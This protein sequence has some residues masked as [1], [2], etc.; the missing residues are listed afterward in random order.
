MGHAVGLDAAL[1][2]D[3]SGMSIV[4]RSRF[5]LSSAA[6]FIC[7]GEAPSPTFAACPARSP[8]SRPRGDVAIVQRGCGDDGVIIIHTASARAIGRV[9]H[10]TAHLHGQHKPDHRQRPL[11]R[12]NINTNRRLRTSRHVHGYAA[13]G[14]GKD[15]DLAKAGAGRG[16]RVRRY[17]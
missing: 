16:T 12:K 2:C 4:F 15:R 9:L 8:G 17:P 10:A 7:A 6:R 13:C 11:G 5:R 14:G 1:V 3:R